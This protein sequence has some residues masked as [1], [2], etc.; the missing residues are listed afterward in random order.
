MPIDAPPIFVP[1]GSGL[2]PGP[3]VP[4]LFDPVEIDVDECEE[5]QGSP[6]ETLNDKGLSVGRQIITLWENRY[7]L[8][9]KFMGKTVQTGPNT[10]THTRPQYYPD[11]PQC[12]VTGIDI[13]PFDDRVLAK[14]GDTRWATY[15]M[16]QL[17]IKYATPS[18][19]QPERRDQG[20][21]T[22][23]VTEDIEPHGQY[24]TLPSH[25]FFW[26]EATAMGIEGHQTIVKNLVAVGE[27]EAPAKLIKTF[28]WTYTR[29]KMAIIPAFMFDFIGSV[30]KKE[31]FSKT[32]NFTFAA[33][34]LLF[35]EPRLSRDVTAAGTQD[36][37]VTMRMIY[38]P[39]T[40]QKYFR[41]GK[42]DPE[43][44]W[45][46]GTAARRTNGTLDG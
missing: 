25:Q 20:G 37:K 26:K 10:W 40:W 31:V 27:T 3:V 6:K 41:A 17:N 46:A 4:V 12:E 35:D 29:H 1:G 23:Y 39:W 9:T 5:L 32:L 42:A 22:V 30:N 15:K 44:M 43:Y 21:T 34:T 33:E 8:A 36:W 45:L 28:A 7:N 11:A 24:I 14:L 38:R 19:N 13:E 18:G 16:A 2:D